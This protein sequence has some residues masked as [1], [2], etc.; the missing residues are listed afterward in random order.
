MASR[1]QPCPNGRAMPYYLCPSC[2]HVV[3]TESHAAFAWC[4]CG[5]PLDAVAMLTDD[6]P[7]AE[8]P[9]LARAEAARRFVSG[10]SAPLVGA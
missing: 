8:H 3:R 6:V 2:L 10:P 9:S 1:P 5:Q 4:R 7:L